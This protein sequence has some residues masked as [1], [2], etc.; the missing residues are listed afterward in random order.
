MS[1]QASSDDESDFSASVFNWLNFACSFAKSLKSLDSSSIIC[2]ASSSINSVDFFSNLRTFA[3]ALSSSSRMMRRASRKESRRKLKGF[4]LFITIVM[5]G[6]CG[7]A[8]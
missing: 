1:L 8:D 2:L 4:Q 7:S 6:A 5:A 3:L